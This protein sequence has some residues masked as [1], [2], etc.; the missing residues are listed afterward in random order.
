LATSDALVLANN[1]M[2]DINNL[3]ALVIAPDDDTIL[4][5]ARR[6]R[7]LVGSGT[8]VVQKSQLTT[9]EI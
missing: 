4:Q 7:S 2:A 5:F 1:R 9:F 6:M 8:V 3:T